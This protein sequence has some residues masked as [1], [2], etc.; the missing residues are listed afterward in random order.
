MNRIPLKSFALFLLLFICVFGCDSGSDGGDGGGDGGG[1]YSGVTSQATISENSTQA[2]AGQTLEVLYGETGQIPFVSGA[3]SSHPPTT[4]L[5]IQWEK[6]LSDKFF[7]KN[8]DFIANDFITGITATETGECGGNVEISGDDGSGRSGKVSVNATIT[9][10]DYCECSLFDG[11]STKIVSNGKITGKGS[12][13]SLYDDEDDEYYLLSG[14]VSYTL[15]NLHAQIYENSSLI[16]DVTADGSMEKTWADSDDGFTENMKMD[17]IRINNLT[18]KT[19]KISNLEI[20]TTADFFSGATI[21]INGRIY[22][23]DYGYVTIQTESSLEIWYSIYPSSGVL[24]ISGSSGSKMRI[25]FFNNGYMVEA[26][27]NG[28]GFYEYDAGTNYW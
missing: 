11:C 21:E 1:G 9:F 16:A 7:R 8:N 28:D 26:D 27:I 15:N 23:H 2:I 19:I 14:Q 22:F 4:N 5:S 24:I 10:N 17:L 18:A 12:G 20:E 25:T 13:V 6:A 3:V